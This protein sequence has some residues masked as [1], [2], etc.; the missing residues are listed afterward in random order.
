MIKVLFICH[1]NI[2]RSPMA[3]LIMKDLVFKRKLEKD[4]LISSCATSREEIG[5]GLYDEAMDILKKHRIPLTDHCA[6]QITSS[7]YKEYDY[8][9]VMEQFNLRN[10]KRIIPDDPDRK[11]FR[12]LDFSSHPKDI[13]DP[14]YS[15]DFETA[16]QEIQEGCI[17]LLNFIQHKN[18]SD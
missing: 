17:A 13:C 8:L 1:G 14:W 3:E 16:Y 9:I 12:L 18:E 6:R 7:D 10:L 5:N 15:G 4:F 2:C 11:I